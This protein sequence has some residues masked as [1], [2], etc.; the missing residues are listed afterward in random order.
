MN[1]VEKARQEVEHREKALKKL[2]DEK[3]N[4]SQSNGALERK[5]AAAERAL[6]LGD[7]TKRKEIRKI[8]DEIDRSRSKGLE[9]LISEAEGALSEAR[10]ALAEAEKI[11]AEQ[12][13]QSVRQE[14]EKRREQFIKS[15]PERGKKIA[16]HVLAARRELGEIP[17]EGSWILDG[18]AQ[19]S[20]EARDFLTQLPDFIDKE[21]EA[22][23]FRRQTYVGF[24]S[25]ILILPFSS[26][27]VEGFVPGHGPLEAGAVSLN[28]HRKRIAELKGELESSR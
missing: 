19:L 24:H 16:Y 2:I 8:E 11:Q 7:E 9:V 13:A 20:A 26:P 12:L 17:V 1:A 14:E 6:A 5:K 27:D 18:Q 15:L 21:G 4:L 23:G 22:Q 25:P 10:A 3:E 28:R